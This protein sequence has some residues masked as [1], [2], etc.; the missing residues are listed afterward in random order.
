MSSKYALVVIVII[1]A[2]LVSGFG[3][4]DAQADTDLVTNI[5][6]D[7]DPVIV[8]ETMEVSCQLTDE[9]NVKT[10]VLNM[11]TDMFCFPPVVMEKGTDGMWHGSS[12]AVTD[13][14]SHHF[15]ITV[16]FNDDNKTW[17]E[18][19]FFTPQEKTN[20]KPD[21][22]DDGGLLPAMGAVAVLAVLTS[23]AMTRRGRSGK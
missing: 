23:L 8:G 2:L 14:V 9:T 18:D 4:N 22:G 17:T 15:N 13:V 3:R 16:T 21:D 1:V 12:D 10:V 6:Y 20:D 5:E 19:Q 11:C 7:P